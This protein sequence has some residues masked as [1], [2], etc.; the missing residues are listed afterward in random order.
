[1][2]WRSEST[3]LILYG[4]RASA[5]L[6]GRHI[7]VPAPSKLHLERCILKQNTSS[8]PGPPNENLQ[9]SHIKS[10]RFSGLAVTLTNT[11]PLLD[12]PSNLSSPSLNSP[13][14]LPLRALL[15]SSFPTHNFPPSYLFLLSIIPS[16]SILS[17]STSLRDT[18]LFSAS[19]S[20][21]L[22]KFH[23]N[24]RSER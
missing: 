11:T 1:M 21:D 22:G 20:P 9:K 3:A 16:V 6:K 12:Y 13:F 5:L 10:L 8:H 4:S 15:R 23:N 7:S 17:T 14:R 18:L 2:G 24:Q 19:N